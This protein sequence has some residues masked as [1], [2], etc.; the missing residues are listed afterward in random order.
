MKLLL[1]K[2]LYIAFCLLIFTSANSQSKSGLKASIEINKQDEMV[3]IN[4][5]AKNESP[6]FKENVSYKLLVLKKSSTGTYSKNL[7]SGDFSILSNQ[8]KLLSNVKINL[9][10]GEILKIYLYLRKNNVL[11]AK[12]SATVTNVERKLETT[13]INEN[14][15]E[16][17]GLVIDEVK[18]KPG[19]DF[20]EFFYQLSSTKGSNY[21]FIVK[22]IEQPGFGRS[23]QIYVK[24]KDQ[25][26]Y[27]F[28]TRPKEEYLKA[29][30]RQAIRAVENYNKY[31]SKLYQSSNY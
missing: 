15:I 10:K 14:S 29:Q 1:N 19:K 18:T 5:Y 17:K 28:I 12:D 21:P 11:I 22:I 27:R 9:Q 13:A 6:G 16:I 26:V 2:T 3:F 4:G 30:A 7:Q 31:R 20:Y 23:S 25:I 24:I 8:K